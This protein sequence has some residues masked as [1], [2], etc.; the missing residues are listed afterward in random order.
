MPLIISL[1]LGFVPMF[2]YALFVYWLDRYEKEPKL[3]LGGVF[4]WGAFV[5]GLGAC[6][7]N[8][9]FG[10]GLQLASGSAELA[11][12]ATTSIVAP[13][14]EELIKAMAVAVVFFLFRKEFDSILDGIIYGSMVGLG[15]SACENFSYIFQ[16]GYLVNGWSGLAVN[17][18]IR[19][20]LLGWL[21]A[22]FTAFTG[23]GFAI[24]RLSDNLF[25]KFIAPFIGLVIAISLHAF[26]NSIGHF[27]NAEG[28]ASLGIVVLTDI[29]GY[30]VIVG[31]I[32]WANIHDRSI[33]K[34]Q[35]AAEVSRGL[36]TEPEYRKAQSPF[37]LTTAIFSGRANS[38]F[39]HL[40]GE[41]AHKKNQLQRMG[42][43]KGNAE[44][45]EELRTMITNLR[46]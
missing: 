32:V 9:S 14:V 16:H 10:I 19:I 27:I 15:F 31:M 25:V 3:L 30:M 33:L 1:L 34:K 18:F 20:I 45:I 6:F 46:K 41:L 12:I 35:L 5:A 21:H 8:T 40:L 26:H 42:D 22:T 2:A 43:E 7:I 4:F 13:V 36:I 29:P 39:Y 17:A 23:I 37:T 44:R 11:S 38:K 28:I 24:S